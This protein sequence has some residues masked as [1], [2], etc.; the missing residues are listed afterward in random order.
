MSPLTE[1]DNGRRIELPDESDFEITLQ[2]E[3]GKIWKLESYDHNLIQTQKQ[4]I[5]ETTDDVGNTVNEFNF[6]FSTYGSGESV[7]K[8]VC[9][10]E[11]D[12][13]QI[14]QKT[15]EVLIICGTMGIIESD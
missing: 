12:Q 1:K 15:Y 8:L 9:V 7:V 5:T 2:A 11:N 4:T 13:Q 10:D 3:K 14:P 6:N